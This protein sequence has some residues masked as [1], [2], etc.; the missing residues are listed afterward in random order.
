MHVPTRFSSRLGDRTGLA[1]LLAASLTFA[2]AAAPAPVATHGPA[3]KA[4]AK[5]AAKPAAVAHAAK[6]AMKP[7]VIAKAPAHAKPAPAKPAPVAK[8][9][10]PV[11]Q[12]AQ[13]LVIQEISWR[14]FG[15][16]VKASGPIEPDFF[17]LP[18]PDRFVIDL[19]DAE[20]ADA[21]LAQTIPVASGGVKQVRLAQKKDAHAVRMVIDCA[22]TLNFQLMQAGDRSTLIIAPA[23]ANTA[24]LAAVLKDGDHYTGGG[25]ELRTIWARETSDG[26]KVHLRGAKA[27]TY[28]L[29]ADDDTHLQLRMPQGRYFGVAP[30]TGKLLTQAAVHAVKEASVVIVNPTHI[31]V[32]LRYNDEEDSAPTVVSQGEGALARQIL[33]AARAYNVPIVRDVPLARALHELEV[34]DQIPEAL[35]EAVAEILRSL[36]D[37]APEE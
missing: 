37:A 34:G 10:A 31:A 7:A 15:L 16:V 18:K 6:P 9:P 32:A 8:K 30:L 1:A 2:T 33:D 4:I 27:L 20:L 19:P 12:A 17:T 3:P 11:R 21:N 22:K 23:G 14:E 5:P 28:S 36:W 29:F 13:P 24:K 26:V 25:Q 35:Y